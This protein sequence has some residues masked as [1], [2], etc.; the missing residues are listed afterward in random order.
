M[1]CVHVHAYELCACTCIWIVHMC[2]HMNCVHVRACMYLF[3]CV[4]VCICAYA[5]VYVSIT[6]ICMC[7]YIYRLEDNFRF[8]FSGSIYIFSLFETVSHRPGTLLWSHPWVGGP[9]L[10]KKAG[11]TSHGEQAST[12]HPSMASASSLA[13]RFLSWLR[14][15]V[16]L[17]MSSPSCLCH[18][19]YH[20]TREL[21]RTQCGWSDWPAIPRHPPA[22]AFPELD[23]KPFNVVL[24]IKLR[25]SSLPEFTSSPRDHHQISGWRNRNVRS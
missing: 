10:C 24:G 16:W 1:N 21:T 13:S 18:G 14:D 3:E 12:Q 7:V 2:M 25:S 8:H 11:G 5:C 6:C 19:V 17:G 23:D 20:S 15:R 4:H 9:V 22:S